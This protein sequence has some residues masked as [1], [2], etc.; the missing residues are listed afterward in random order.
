MAQEVQI[1]EFQSLPEVPDKPL[2]E[3][4]AHQAE[5]NVKIYNKLARE[6]IAGE[7]SG[8]LMYR[9]K[10]LIALYFDMM[11]MPNPTDEMRALEAAE[12]FVRHRT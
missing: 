10:R 2:P 1:C 8:Q 7:S 3:L 5:E 4:T 12:K 9:D 6:Q 11:A